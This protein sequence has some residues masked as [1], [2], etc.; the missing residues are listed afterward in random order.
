MIG[1][2][3]FFSRRFDQAVPML[4]LAVQHNQS[5]PSSYRYLAACFAHLG[6][7]DEAREVI[8][9]LRGIT[10]LTIPGPSTTYM[11]KPEHRELFLSGLRL[12]AGEKT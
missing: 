6:R 1:A 12:A 3:H 10:S 5:F 11:R 4:R 2:A 7:I 8:R 9:R